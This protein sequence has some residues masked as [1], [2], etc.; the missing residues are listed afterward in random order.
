MQTGTKRLLLVAS[1]VLLQLIAVYALVLGLQR[2]L[3]TQFVDNAQVT[4]D[5]LA[6]GVVDRSR[7]F[8]RPVQDAVSVGVELMNQGILDDRD[9]LVLENYFEAQLATTPWLA[10]MFLGRSDG[11]FVYLARNEFGMRTKRI[12]LD[13]DVRT[14]ELVQRDSAGVLSERW[15]DTDD[16]YDPRERSW[17][18]KAQ[19]SDT[20]AWSDPYVFFSSGLQ[21]ISVAA[22]SANGVVMGADVE[23]DE[24]SAFI[25]VIPH[26]ESGTALIIDDALNVIASSGSLGLR[27]DP[28]DATIPKL[29]DVAKAPLLSLH[30]ATSS[31]VASDALVEIEIE[32]DTYL[33]LARTFPIADTVDRWTLLVQMQADDYAGGALN[34]FNRQIMLLGALSIGLGTLALGGMIWLHRTSRNVVVEAT[35]DPI[36][37]ALYRHQFERILSE[38]FV[39]RSTEAGKQLGVM[40]VEAL[41]LRR[42][43]DRLGNGCRNLVIANIGHRLAAV[44]GEADL[45]GITSE[46]R[47]LIAVE[48]E[49]R[50]ALRERFAR[51]HEAVTTDEQMT[52]PF[53]PQALKIASG[54]AVLEVG[55]PVVNLLPRA[56]EALSNGIESGLSGCQQAAGIDGHGLLSLDRAA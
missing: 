51:I 34:F 35:R 1:I 4:L 45:L 50:Q 33:G 12:I 44:L 41:G 18:L 6:D 42:L 55:E 37:G 54:A 30:A 10:G 24:L 47:Y 56:R 49:D 22:R 46:G 40:V 20:V 53:G 15:T 23:L 32:H 48:A 52:T 25:D 43:G 26:A 21:G 5:D 14:V 38:R 36:S 29:A 9:D 19:A 27:A 2:E 13:D 8:L 39:N 17:Y 11:S 31:E 7:R 28:T 3:T 16:D